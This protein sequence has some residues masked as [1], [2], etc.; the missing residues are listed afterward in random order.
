MQNMF[1]R[2][3]I[4][5]CMAIAM[6]LACSDKASTAVG[7]H[8]INAT[9]QCRA[10]NFESAFLH[11]TQPLQIEHP[12]TINLQFPGDWQIKQVKARLVGANM[13]MGQIPIQ[14]E[15]AEQANEFSGV[16]LVVACTSSDMVWR[17]EVD[18]ESQKPDQHHMLHWT[19]STE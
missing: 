6:L 14:L 13:Q 8:C 17:L 1:Y 18:V 10:D 2:N 5:L 7:Q 3:N 19:F 11:L 4:V 9:E 15:P 16:L 12:I